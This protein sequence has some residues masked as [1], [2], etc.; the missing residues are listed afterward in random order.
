MNQPF[1]QRVP[2]R[3]PPAQ[4]AT[5]VPR[6]LCSCHPDSLIMAPKHRMPAICICHR[7]AVKRMCVQEKHGTC[8]ARIA[9]AGIPGDLGRT[10]S[11]KGRPECNSTT[12]ATMWRSL[13]DVLS[14]RSQT[15][16]VTCVWFKLPGVRVGRVKQEAPRVDKSTDRAEGG[17]WAGGRREGGNVF[18]TRERTGNVVNATYVNVANSTLCARHLSYK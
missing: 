7:G 18:G 1:A 10:P 8:R 15:Q 12:C 4:W 17:G 9:V 3:T 13:K 2:L 16:E 5:I 11:A 6:G 14:G